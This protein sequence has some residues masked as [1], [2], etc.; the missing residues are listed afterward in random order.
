MANQKTSKDFG[1]AVRAWR[2]EKEIGLRRFAELVGMSATYLS[3]I[4]R[5]DFPPP[6]EEKIKAI[7]KGLGRDADEL[8]ALAGRVA[9]DLEEIIQQNPRE[10]ATFLRAA[11]SLPSKDIEQLTKQVERKQRKQ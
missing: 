9:S 11:R 4:E 2:E 5:G 3:K 10:M 1:S 6:G 8:L 7:A